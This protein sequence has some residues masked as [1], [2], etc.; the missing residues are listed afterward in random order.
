MKRLIVATLVA[1][2]VLASSGCEWRGLNSL[3]LPGTSTSEGDGTSSYTIQAQLPDVVVIQQNTRVRVAD[4]NVGN[5]TKI[6][7]QDW[8]AL[9]TMR[10]DGNVHLPANAT[11]KVGQTSLLGSMHIELAPPTDEAPEGELKDGSVI[12]LSRASTYPTT[13]QTLASVSIL[14]NGGGLGQLQEINKAF[15][16]ALTG[17]EDDMRSLLTQLDTFIA[18]LNDQTDDIITATER[19]NSLAG[20]VAA[21]DQKVDRALTTIP[22]ALKVL[23][24]SRTKL[25]DAIDAVGKFSAVAASTVDQTKESFVDNLRNIAP[26]F[27]ELANAGP[28]LTRGLD[29]LS[30]YPWVK[31][32]VAN[33]FRGDFA[34]ITLVID[35]TLSRLD[36][37]L[38]TGTRWE[39]NLTELELQWGR[40]I[41][42]MPSPYTAGNPLIAPYHWDSY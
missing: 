31:S 7:V 15:A 23:A 29:F 25:A 19:L 34:N 8:H 18:Q 12:P 20:Q 42:Q 33:W 35:L 14:L 38:F 36:S 1:V 30:T 37:G 6:E 4:V 32:T 22:Q 28:A 39:G 40:T 21:N 17:R 5:V 13:E 24:D 3:S 16:T 41:G 26:V 11:A 10:I 2:C 9:V 27:R